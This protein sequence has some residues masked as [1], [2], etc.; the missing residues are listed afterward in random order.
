MSFSSQVKEELCRGSVSK[1]CCA[2]AESYGVLL[3]CNRFCAD[4]IRIITASVP[5]AERLPRLFRRAFGFGFDSARMPQGRSK[6]LLRITDAE[7]IA[8]V[9]RAYGYEPESNLVHHINLA[10]VESD[11]D[12]QAFLR[13]AF[14]AGG[15]LTEPSE[16]YH[17]E[18]VTDHASVSRELHSLLLEAGFDPKNSARAGHWVTYFKRSDAIEDFLTTVGAPL[19]AMGM[20]EA[21]VQK[22]MNNTINRRTN[23]DMGNAGRVSGA[24]QEQLAA[25]RRLEE[26]AG[27]D[28]LPAPLQETALL[29]IANPDSGLAELAMLADPPVSKS[30]MA[31]RMRRLIELG[32]HHTILDR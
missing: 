5:F 26:S 3:F 28:A 17:L 32:Q 10:A 24:S 27:L 13:G 1:K 16:R 8:A 19:S 9:F 21:K 6:G 30:C 15:S 23:C 12:R 18:M 31:H 22:N 14:L 20:M 4:D 11:C 7:K 25:I 2:L 29:R